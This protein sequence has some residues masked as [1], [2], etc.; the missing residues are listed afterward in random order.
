MKEDWT[1]NVVVFG[2][3]KCIFRR[4]AIAVPLLQTASS[5]SFALKSVVINAKT[6]QGRLGATQE[7]RAASY[8]LRVARAPGQLEARGERVSHSFPPTALKANERLFPVY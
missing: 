7:P 3:S 5:L 1:F 6:V 2:S 8:E 4:K